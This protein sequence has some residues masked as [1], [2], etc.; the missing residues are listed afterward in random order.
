L[1]LSSNLMN[2]EKCRKASKILLV[3]VKLKKVNEKRIMTDQ[4]KPAI[5]QV[6]LY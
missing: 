1:Q 6:F 3:I 2:L 4:L 5:W